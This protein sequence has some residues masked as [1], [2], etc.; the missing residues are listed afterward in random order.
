MPFHLEVK[1]S[2]TYHTIFSKRPIVKMGHLTIK[3]KNKNFPIEF[4]RKTTV[5]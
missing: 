5:W 3:S 2:I 1:F 4:L